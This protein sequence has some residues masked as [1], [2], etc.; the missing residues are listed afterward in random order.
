MT[1][2]FPNTQSPTS[3]AF[4]TF[5]YPSIQPSSMCVFHLSTHS[6]NREFT[7]IL[8]LSPFPFLYFFFFCKPLSILSKLSYLL[9]Y[10]LSDSCH[11]SLYCSNCPTVGQWSHFDL[12]PMSFCWVPIRFWECW[13][14]VV[15]G[16]PDSPCTSSIPALEPAVSQVHVSGDCHLKLGYEP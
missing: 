12:A 14:F 2:W 4:Q 7:V 10:L 1:N 6:K 5:F 8:L 11:Y 13:Y 9:N 15:E 3:G 16:G